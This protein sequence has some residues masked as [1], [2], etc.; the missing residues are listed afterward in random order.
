V[1]T[2]KGEAPG[3]FDVKICGFSVQAIK[4]G[5]LDTAAKRK[6][7]CNQVVKSRMNGE[8]VYRLKRAIQR[9]PGGSW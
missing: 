2:A 7:I 6:S 1:W 4:L 3:L 9:R 8:I 5:L